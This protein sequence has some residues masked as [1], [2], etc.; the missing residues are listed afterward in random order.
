MSGF[1]LRFA[2]ANTLIGPAGEAGALY[3]VE[4][5]SYPYLPGHEKVRWLWQ[6]A[7]LADVLETDLSIHRVSRAYPAE[8]YLP[9]VEG[10]VDE[11]FADGRAWRAYLAGHEDHLADLRVHLPEVY[12]VVSLR[13]ERQA[14]RTPLLGELYRV[15]RQVEGFFGVAATEPIR[16]SELERLAAIEA[17][18]FDQVATIL[19][20]ARVSR[21]EPH[22]LEWLLRRAACRGVG[23]PE[24]SPDWRPDAR[25]IRSR[26]GEELSYEPLES[27]LVRCGSAAICEQD[28]ALVVDADECRSF[29]AMLCLESL[30]EEARFPGP[31][32]ELLSAPLEWL[33]FPVDAVLHA[34]FVTNKDAVGQVRKRVLD[35]DA[36]FDEEASGYHGASMRSDENRRLA[37][38][39]E[40]ALQSEEHPPLLDATISFAVGAESPEELE[41]RVER[42]RD[43]FRNMRV[44][45]RRPLG[46]QA[47]LYLDHLPR[48]DTGRV[49][50]YREVVLVE[51]FGGLMPIASHFAGDPDGVYV[52]RTTGNR[53]V[54]FDPLAAAA[55]DRPPSILMAGTLGSGK[56]V[57]AQLLCYQAAKR[58]SLV[59]DVDPKP[60]HALAGLPDLAER[61]EVIELSEEQGR[62]GLLDPLR[63]APEALRGDLASAYLMDVLPRGP[64]SQAWEAHVRRAVKETH[65]AGGGTLAVVE[66]LRAS[67]HPAAREAA[68]ALEGYAE[69]GL[70]ALAFGEGSELADPELE[71]DITA[72]RADVLSLP[73]AGTARESWSADERLSVA[74]LK[75]VASYAMRLT[76]D[77]ARHACVLIDEAWLLL[78]S[79]EGR[80]LLDRLLRLG[81]SQNTTLILATQSLADVEGATDL[82]GSFFMF[83]QRSEAEAR[84][85]LELLGLDPEDPSLVAQVRGYERGLCLMRDVR[86]HIAEVQIDLVYPDLLEALDTSPR[87]HAESAEQVAA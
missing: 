79:Q 56:T 83:G 42:V 5:I 53:P 71:R 32:A 63:V 68:L 38:E 35:A 46:L 17:Q 76:R 8:D 49:R 60:D 10:L 67:E 15:R 74:T 43:S 37:R 57:A 14:G 81:R 1:P 85:A 75:L 66:R 84:R 16:Q 19:R 27:D 12:L 24:L 72:I 55:S 39:L 51:Q 23:E 59:V 86:G 20:P 2:V 73:A 87:R 50:E 18:V 80:R 33:G 52:G 58:G 44:T 28:R 25:I 47:D 4:P 62:R 41:R 6:L 29:Q 34:R 11:R 3:R 64:A 69:E 13:G 7:A 82:I 40:Q 30:P 36:I 9:R 65:A 77:P 70:G 54:G 45:I 21:T 31:R 78:A 26:D 48:P 61:A 22:E